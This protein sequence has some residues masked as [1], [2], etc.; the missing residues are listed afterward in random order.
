MGGINPDYVRFWQGSSMNECSKYTPRYDLKK[1]S[2]KE[3]DRK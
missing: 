3:R 2:V 1:E